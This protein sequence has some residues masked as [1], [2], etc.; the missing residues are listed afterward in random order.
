MSMET[1]NSQSW[2]P[3]W[4]DVFSSQNWGK[5][6]AESLIRFIA[7]NFY[8]KDRKSTTIL[9][10]GCGPGANIWYLSREHFD[11]YGIDGSKTAIDLA[12]RRLQ[13][14]KL[15]ANLIV[16]DI[17]SLP[18]EAGLFDGIIDVECIYTNNRQN[19]ETTL[20]G[21]QRV[22]KNDG[23]F[24]SRTFAEDMFLGNKKQEL[25]NFEYSNIKEAL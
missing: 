4:E 2:D 8:K 1:K 16:G 15:N 10:V 25:T 3:V 20:K 21:I 11:A 17:I 22:L 24:Y 13:S 5:Y 7:N 19:S 23:L 18:Y 6:P 12:K 14:E 9:E